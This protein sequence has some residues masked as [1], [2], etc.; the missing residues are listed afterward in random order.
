MKLPGLR[1]ERSREEM[2]I[3]AGSVSRLYNA[4]YWMMC[5]ISGAVI[6]TIRKMCVK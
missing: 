3:P 2:I 4:A 6:H 1:R 5:D